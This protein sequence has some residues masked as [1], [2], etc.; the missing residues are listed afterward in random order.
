MLLP[1]WISKEFIMI[2]NITI[3]I[4]VSNNDLPQVVRNHWIVLIWLYL[5]IELKVN[6]AI[7]SNEIWDS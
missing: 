2:N 5:N 4:E 3:A 6:S 1:H 7:L